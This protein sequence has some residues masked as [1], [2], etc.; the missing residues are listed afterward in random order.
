MAKNK[1]LYDT[2][3]VSPDASTADIR[4]AR[5]KRAK[6]THPDTGGSKQAFHELQHAYA[7][8]SNPDTRAR[9]DSTGEEEAGELSSL[10][11]RALKHLAHLL[12]ALLDAPL[13]VCGLDLVAELKGMLDKARQGP[14]AHIERL[15]SLRDRATACAKRLKHKSDASPSLVAILRSTAESADRTIDQ[16]Q[17]KLA[18]IDR[19]LEIA[20]SYTFTPD[21]DVALKNAA[22]FVL[23]GLTGRGF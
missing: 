23:N 21:R 10:D 3:G 19:A 14:L 5:R 13:D 7:V 22:A 1:K 11:E 17:R 8:L 12:R 4:R 2:L 16:E 15:K 6:D 18:E 20:S 9:Y